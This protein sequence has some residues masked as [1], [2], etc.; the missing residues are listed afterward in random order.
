MAFCYQETGLRAEAEDCYQT[1]VEN[2]DHSIDIRPQL[3][4]MCKE[5]GSSERSSKILKQ[6]SVAAN[7]RLKRS[8]ETTAAREND[9]AVDPSSPSAT[10]LAS[11]PKAFFKPSALERGKRLREQEQRE[12]DRE[13]RMYGHFLHLQ[14]SIEKSRLGDELA[15]LEWKSAAKTLIQ[16]FRSNSIFYPTDKYMRFFGYTSEARAR[17]AA[18]KPNQATT[19]TQDVNVD[20]EHLSCRFIYRESHENANICP[21]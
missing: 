21:E 7:E 14:A 13:S 17:S 9:Q 6:L 4:A 20:P 12:R 1:V 18:T 10:M 19:E 15:K 8:G 3:I 5:H 2:G 16:D 11:R